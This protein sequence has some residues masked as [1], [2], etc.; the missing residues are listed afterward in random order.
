MDHGKIQQ[1]ATPKELLQ[2]PATDFVKKLVAKQRRMCFLPEGQLKDCAYCGAA[3][4]RKSHGLRRR[5]RFQR[6]RCHHTQKG[7]PDDF[8]ESRYDPVK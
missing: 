1:Y 8:W 6:N 3:G 4:M 7:G 5:K 2:N